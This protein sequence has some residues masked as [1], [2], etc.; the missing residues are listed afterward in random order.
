MGSVYED[1]AENRSPSTYSRRPRA[2]DTT[3]LETEKDGKKKGEGEF[4][5]SERRT[6][7]RGKNQHIA[8]ARCHLIQSG[9]D[10]APPGRKKDGHLH[11]LQVAY[12]K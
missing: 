11:T 1:N 5:E 3:E 8:I 9:C 6:K 10:S 7:K 2:I 12:R 4:V